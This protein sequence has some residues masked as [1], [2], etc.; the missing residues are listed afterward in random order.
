[1]EESLY[2]VKMRAALGGAHEKGGK[3]ISGAERVVT[4][5]EL[6]STLSQLVQRAQNH[7]KGCPD[8]INLQIER[9]DKSKLSSLTALPV[10]TINSDSKA[11]S[12]KICREILTLAGIK[13]EVVK[14][15]FENMLSG[16]APDGQNMRGA[17]LMD[18]HS[19]QR[20]EP[21]RYRG[22]RVTGMD[23]DPGIKKELAQKLGVCGINND[24]AR[25]ALCL[26]SKVAAVKGIKAELCWSDDP[27]YTAGYIAVPAWGYLRINHM[28]DKG[29]EKGGRVFFVDTNAIEVE[30]IIQALEETP[31]L[32]TEL[33]AMH[34]NIDWELFKHNFI[35]QEG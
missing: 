8:Y 2:S 20:L 10:F 26:A 14:T 3:H 11:S 29:S 35:P 24:H 22:I 16:P 12:H 15:A 1:M 21:D 28:K 6:F 34:G 30:K 13:P 7:E 25:E 33:S 17:I 18:I 32:L 31:C 5:A 19:G 4:D 9:L 23:Y 27:G